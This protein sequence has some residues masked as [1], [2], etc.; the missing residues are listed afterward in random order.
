MKEKDFSAILKE[1][2]TYLGLSQQDFSK[3]L[4][5]KLRM[6]NAYEN[7]DFDQSKGDVRRIRILQRLDEAKK[8]RAIE[9][10]RMDDHAYAQVGD[11]AERVARLENNIKDLQATVLKLINKVGLG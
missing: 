2:R 4:G 5:I 1:A 6:Y 10:K 11:I 7:G 8:K 3:V 9:E